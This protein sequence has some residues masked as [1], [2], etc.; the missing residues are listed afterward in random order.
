MDYYP[1]IMRHKAALCTFCTQ[2]RVKVVTKISGLIPT[3]PKTFLWTERCVYSADVI[4]EVA[5]NKLFEILSANFQTVEKKLRKLMVIRF[6]TKIPGIR[7]A[8]PGAM[9]A[10]ICK[11][12]V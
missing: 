2:V 1:V 11:S 3:V 7:L 8:I 4:R 6:A 12:L 5:A 10:G 9:A